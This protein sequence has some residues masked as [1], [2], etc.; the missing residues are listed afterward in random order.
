MGGVQ[1]DGKTPVFIGT[2]A[3]RVDRLQRLGIEANDLALASI[4]AES[5]DYTDDE[6]SAIHQAMSDAMDTCDMEMTRFKLS[7]KAD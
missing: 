3:A 7:L 4:I 5:G 1:L 6:R 2:M